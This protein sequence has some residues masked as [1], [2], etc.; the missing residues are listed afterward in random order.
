M[1]KDW[2]KE[3]DEIF[4]TGVGGSLVYKGEEQG[5][6]E[7]GVRQFI[8]NAISQTRKETLEEVKKNNKF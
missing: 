6:V 2:E 8:K 5:V 7:L 3:F 1:K 4:A